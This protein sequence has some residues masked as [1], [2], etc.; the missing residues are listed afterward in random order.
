[1]K[2]TNIVCPKIYLWCIDQMECAEGGSRDLTPGREYKIEGNDNRGYFK[3]RDN[4][5]TLK[6]YHPVYFRRPWFN[7]N[8]R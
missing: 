8:T 1:M 5:G 2:D 6:E 7:L 3:I 4:D